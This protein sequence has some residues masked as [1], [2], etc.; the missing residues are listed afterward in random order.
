MSTAN[1]PEL[2]VAVGSDFAELALKNLLREFPNHPGHV[3]TG[4]A[5][6]QTPRQWHPIFFGCFDWH[7]AVHGYWL[8][9]RTYRLFPSLP[10][11]LPIKNHF[12]Q[13]VTRSNVETEISYF[14]RAPAFERPYGWAWLLMLC[15]ELKR[16]NTQQSQSWLGTLQPLANLIRD[17]FL[18]YFPK[19][20][21]PNRVG[22]HGN[23]AFAMVLA[24]QF[25]EQFADQNLQTAID[26]KAR[27]WFLNDRDCQVWEP[28]QNDFLS[29]AL[30]E[31]RCLLQVLP[32]ADYQKW[33]GGFLPELASGQPAA[34]FQPAVPSDRTDGQISHLDGLNFSRAWCLN[35]IAKSLEEIDPAKR[36][37]QEAADLHIN[38]SFPNI[39]GHYAGEHWLATFALLALT[40]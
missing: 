16:I 31:A 26:E 18:D 28:S 33:L 6:F 11:R 9:A 15:A 38:T 29:P 25:S 17:Q 24:R 39:T 5:D 7:S 32:A 27:Q 13:F 4:P 19:A 14:Q 23:I 21:Y 22:T 37:L 8:L 30:I 12:D 10:Q 40:D 35:A 34:L 2:S 36:L 3:F 1:K 20:T